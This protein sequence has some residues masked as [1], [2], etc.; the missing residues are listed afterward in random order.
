M[1]DLLNRLMQASNE[2]NSSND[3]SKENSSSEETQELRVAKVAEREVNAPEALGISKERQEIVGAAYT[4]IIEEHMEKEYGMDEFSVCVDMIEF[5]DTK[6]E[7][8]WMTDSFRK[9]CREAEKKMMEAHPLLAMLKK[10][11]GDD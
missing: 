8:F 10:M 4:R 7:A 2:E 9:T 6:E 5:A 11:K 1:S 3:D